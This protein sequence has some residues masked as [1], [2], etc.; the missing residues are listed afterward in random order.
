MPRSAWTSGAVLPSALMITT[1]YGPSEIGQVSSCV[2]APAAFATHQSSVSGA[3]SGPAMPLTSWVLR[4]IG[5]S[6]FTSSV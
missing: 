3:T 1:E 5:Y 2:P 6:T 4:A